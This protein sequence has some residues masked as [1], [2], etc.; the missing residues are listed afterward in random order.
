LATLKSEA[1]S[2][3]ELKRRVP[4]RM[5]GAAVSVAFVY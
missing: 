5:S 3:A 2:L 4:T 1:L